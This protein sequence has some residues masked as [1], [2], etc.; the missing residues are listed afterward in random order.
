M[1]TYLTGDATAPAVSGDKIIAHICNDV[2]GW[3][4]GFVLAITKRYP[5]AECA[6]RNWYQNT[7]DPSRIDPAFK[8]GEVQFVSVDDHTYVANMIGQHGIMPNNGVQP[9]RYDAL[10]RCLQHVSWFAN[11]LRDVSIHM[12]RIGCG[13]AGGR[14]HLIEPIILGA[15]SNVPI[16]VYDFDAGDATT[17]AWNK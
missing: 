13:L 16:Y 14:W 1:I 9:I 2:G 3:G 8:L 12:P 7:P 17:I 11:H 10:E 6:Y 4:R 5:S 15:I